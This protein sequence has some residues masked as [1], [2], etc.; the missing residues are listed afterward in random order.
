MNKAHIFENQIV[1]FCSQER[2]RYNLWVYD[3]EDNLQVFTQEKPNTVHLWFQFYAISNLYWKIMESFCVEKIKGFSFYN[4]T[5]MKFFV[6]KYLFCRTNIPNIKLQRLR[7]GQLTQESFQNLMKIHPR[8]WR[9]LFEIIKIF[10]EQL[11]KETEKSLEKQCSILFG[12]NKPVSQPHDWIITYCNLVAFWDKFG[13]NYYDILRLPQETFLFLKKIM[14]LES[15]YRN[16][17]L[18]SNK[19]SHS[20]TRNNRGV[21]F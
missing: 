19:S 7:N 21:S 3:R 18:S 11:D 4:H 10:P 15:D 6:I 17:S 9:S 14:S 12:Q 8:I 16:K 5:E 20:P 13:M 1:N 2:K